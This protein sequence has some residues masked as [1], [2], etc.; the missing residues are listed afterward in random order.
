MLP[1]FELLMPE[2]LPEALMMLGDRQPDASPLA[3]GTNLIPDLRSGKRC[4]DVLVNVQGLRELREIRR[5]NGHVVVGG[6]VTI[7]Q[8]L[9]SQLVTEHGAVLVAAARCFANPLVRNRATVGGNLGNASPAADL[10]PPLLV[11]DSEVELSTSDGRRWVPLQD[12]FVHVCDTVCE[13]SELITAVRW[14]VPRARSIGDFHKVMLRKSMAISVVSAAVQIAWDEEGCCEEVRIA[15][16]AVAPTPVRAY[17][18]EE[19]LKGEPLTWELIQEARPLACGAVSCI[20]DVRSSAG[21]REQVTAVLVRRLLTQLA[22][23]SR[24]WGGDR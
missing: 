2:S 22:E 12:F 13:P 1:R 19:L 23:E 10:A 5:D 21:Y 7:A 16:G 11:L 9:E 3:G 4:P 6:G 20:D 8:L 18:A 17:E 24:V 14:P 15:L